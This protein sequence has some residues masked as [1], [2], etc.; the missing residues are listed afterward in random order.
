MIAADTTRLALVAAVHKPLRQPVEPIEPPGFLQAITA[1]LDL[2]QVLEALTGYLERAVG[3]S[4][5]EYRN[6]GMDIALQGGKPDRHRLEYNLTL[7]GEG[8]G[9]LA[10]MRGRRFSEDEQMRVEALLGLATPALKNALRYQTVLNLLE[11]DTLTGLGNRRALSRQGVQW[12]A[13]AS[14]QNRP[15]SMLAL[16][17]DDF[18]VIDASFEDPLGD[19]LLCGIADT[20]RA[21]IRISDLCVRMGRS[22]IAVLLPGADLINAIDCAE[23]IRLAI[24]T[25]TIPTQDDESIRVSASI[26]VAAYRPGMNI[27]SLY[28]QA[29]DALYAAKRSGRNR[30]MA[31]V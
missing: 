18:D 14:R 10:L 21:N 20:L 31:T 19:R 30:V 24:A 25:C 22:E 9:V 8:V 1:S 16:D 23:R 4:G 13:D 17:L 26:G 11:R 3:H 29:A 12:L 6:A 27:D 28:H 15:L 7:S 2:D 5:W